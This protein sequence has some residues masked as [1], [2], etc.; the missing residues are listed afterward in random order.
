MKD[1]KVGAEHLIY[2]IIIFVIFISFTLVLSFG[3]IPNANSILGVAATVSSIILSI[4][5]ILLSLIDVAGQR[6]SVVDL[7]ETADKLNATSAKSQDLLLEMINKI[8]QI[9]VIRD[10]LLEDSVANAEWR[11]EVQNSLEAIKGTGNGENKIVV[12]LL[13]KIEESNNDYKY[14][15][16]S[17]SDIFDM[18]LKPIQTTGSTNIARNINVINDYIYRNYLRGSSEKLNTLVDKIREET[19]LNRTRIKYAINKLIDNGNL[20]KTISSKTQEEYIH[21]N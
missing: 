15:Q 12:D 11:K 10:S 17:L 19:G 21:I 16:L 20:S 7:K 1:K 18:D 9:E 13:K 3:D 5:A 2:M 8:E 14:K 4:I 6:Q